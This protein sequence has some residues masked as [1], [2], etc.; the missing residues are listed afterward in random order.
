M[1]LC[2]ASGLD[3]YASLHP[4]FPTVAEFLARTDLKALPEGRLELKGEELYVS[5]SPQARTRPPEEAPLEA[6]RAYIDVQL[7]LEGTDIMGWAPL[8]DCQDIATPYDP[9]KDILFF[10]D[11]PKTFF[12]V[13]PG[14][15]AI[16]FPED[17]HAP[18][19]GNGGHVQKLVVKV[20]V[21][22]P[23]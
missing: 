1:I 7:V 4:S 12:Q 22:S 14:Q 21:A 9:G 17:A 18:L 19:I 15:V 2:P 13:Q 16:F 8:A 20:K 6:H 11:T 5:C 10:R 3:R 23:S